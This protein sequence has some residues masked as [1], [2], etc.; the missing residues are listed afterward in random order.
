MI[1]SE[2]LW[3][4]LVCQILVLKPIFMHDPISSCSSRC[5][6]KM[7]NQSFL[8]PHNLRVMKNKSILS[9]GLPVSIFCGPVSPC[10]ICV[11]PFS[12]AKEIPLKILIF[13]A[14]FFCIQKQ[15]YWEFLLVINSI[16]VN[17]WVQAFRKASILVPLLSWCYHKFHDIVVTF[18]NLVIF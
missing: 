14:W 3:D 7:K 6:S 17:N 9:C 18:S 11:L 4:A 5:P 8:P 15:K 12:R 10:P 1:I 13:Q 16:Y 2:Y